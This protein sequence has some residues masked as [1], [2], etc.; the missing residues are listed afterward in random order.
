VTFP[1]FNAP[2]S[3]NTVVSGVSA[4]KYL[5]L[6]PLIKTMY[7]LLASKFTKVDETPTQACVASLK[8]FKDVPPA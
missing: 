4:N 5:A 7:A 8:T 3:L 1:I 6:L 2:F